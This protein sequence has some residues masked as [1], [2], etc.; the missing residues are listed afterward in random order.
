M[1]LR[2][3]RRRLPAA[4]CARCSAIAERRRAAEQLAVEMATW[5]APV[6]VL[7]QA[8]ELDGPP[9]D[10]PGAPL[11]PPAG[12]PRFHFGVTERWIFDE[13]AR[14]QPD[15]RLTTWSTSV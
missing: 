11:V 9:A 7:R 6:D 15:R 5:P 13:V 1:K 12:Y 4:G 14:T 10:G 8:L 2:L 3:R